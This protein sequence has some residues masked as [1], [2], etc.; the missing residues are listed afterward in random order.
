[1]K[2]CVRLNE[3]MPGQ[4]AVVTRLT[5]NGGLRRRLQDLGLA[6]G[7]EVACVQY[8]PLG[9]PVA[10]EVCGTIIALRRKDA[11]EIEVEEVAYHGCDERQ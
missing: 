2:Q 1:M 4:H 6:Q 7:S 10:Y 11:Y 9:D 8:S 3:L 5:S